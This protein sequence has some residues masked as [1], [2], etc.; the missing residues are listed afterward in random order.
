MSL[1]LAPIDDWLRVL[2]TARY[3]RA[4]QISWRVRRVLATRLRRRR[5]ISTRALHE[6]ESL[7]QSGEPFPEIPK[8]ARHCVQGSDR[9]AELERGELTLVNQ[10]LPFTIHSPD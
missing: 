9:L 7:H 2:R 4:S 8:F 6:S 5:I 3:L 10:T 1:R